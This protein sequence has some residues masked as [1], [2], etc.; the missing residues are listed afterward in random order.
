MA[1]EAEAASAEDAIHLRGTGA[2]HPPY[3]RRPKL[4]AY[5]A[6][7][8]ASDDFRVDDALPEICNS[9]DCGPAFGFPQPLGPVLGVLVKNSLE[10]EQQPVRFRPPAAST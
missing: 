3:F 5:V 8:F 7:A 4:A 6:F 9:S 2:R 10:R 1:A